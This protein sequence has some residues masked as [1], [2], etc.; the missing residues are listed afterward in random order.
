MF[1]SGLGGKPADDVETRIYPRRCVPSFV[2]YSPE[3]FRPLLD[4]AGPLQVSNS[5]CRPGRRSVYGV[6]PIEAAIDVIA[7]IVTRTCWLLR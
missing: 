6:Q 2:K 4:S 5:C 3:K 7:A 1:F